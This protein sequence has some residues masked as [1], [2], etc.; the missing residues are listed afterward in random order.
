MSHSNIVQNPNEINRDASTM[1]SPSGEEHDM[2]SQSSLLIP[3]YDDL[4]ISG[5]MQIK[6]IQEIDK[7]GNIIP[8]LFVLI[9]LF[10]SVTMSDTNSI[11]P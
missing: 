6:R 3:E 1:D 5:L 8:K 2:S 10:S 11:L 4:R 9:F 7:K